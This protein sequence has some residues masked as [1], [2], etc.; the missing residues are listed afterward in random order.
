MRVSEKAAMPFRYEFM[1]PIG[2]TFCTFAVPLTLY[3]L[4][5]AS[6]TGGA[7]TLVPLH[8]PGWSAD[9]ALFSWRGSAAVYVWFGVQLMLHALLPAKRRLGV[10]EP[11]GKQW[12]YRLNGV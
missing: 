5:F 6:N 12:A 8:V 3:L 4:T 11:D 2:T 7:L 10:S 1:G 9:T